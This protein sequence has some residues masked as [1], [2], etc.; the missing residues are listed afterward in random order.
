M[1]S[2]MRWLVGF[3]VAAAAIVGLWS[4]VASAVSGGGATDQADDTVQ[5]FGLDCDDEVV[6][7]LALDCVETTT[8][9]GSTGNPTTTTEAQVT[10]TVQIADT[11]TSLV[12][13]TTTAPTTAPTTE[14]NP[15]TTGETQVITAPPTLPRTGLSATA[16]LAVVGLLFVAVGVVIV[17]DQRR[18]GP[19]P[20]EVRV[21]D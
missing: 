10:T 17:A 1:T 11:T 20:I 14:P 12:T 7:C 15:T 9:V 19:T 16:V 3:A 18:R 2:K 21:R 13:T 5:C 4:A 8:T 6:E